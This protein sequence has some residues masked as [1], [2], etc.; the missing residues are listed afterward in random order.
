MPTFV[1]LVSGIWIVSSFSCG[2]KLRILS[3]IQLTTGKTPGA[4]IRISCWR[5]DL[6]STQEHISCKI[7][8]MTTFFELA[9]RNDKVRFCWH[10]STPMCRHG[11]SCWCP[12]NKVEYTAASKS[13]EQAHLKSGP[14][15][16]LHGKPSSILARIGD[17][18]AAP[19]NQR[20]S[21]VFK[22]LNINF[23]RR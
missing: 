4:G 14:S 16:T 12:K 5:W 17:L 13:I 8:E 21:A 9:L 1:V 11:A 6:W 20:R 18:R 22:P 19:A 2:Q 10:L 3:Q 23:T 7:S 15:R